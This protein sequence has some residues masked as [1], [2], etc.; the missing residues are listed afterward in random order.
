LPWTLFGQGPRCTEANICAKRVVVKKATPAFVG[1][2]SKPSS[3]ILE[4]TGGWNT[5]VLIRNGMVATP[6]ALFEADILTEGEKITKI[7][8]TGI[9]NKADVTLDATDKVVVPGIIDSHTHLELGF[10]GAETK[11]SFET[12]TRAAAFGGVTTLINYAI[13]GPGEGCLSRIDKDLESARRQAWIDF[14]IHGVITEPVPDPIEELTKYVTAGV[15]S[16][17]LF[18]TYRGAG[19]MSDDAVLHRVFTLLSQVNGL[20]GVHAENDAIV[21]RLTQEFVRLGKTGAESYPLSRPDYSEEEA[22]SRAAFFAMLC[23]SP[24]Y[25]AHLS[26]R[27]ALSVVQ[28]RRVM[29]RRLFVETCPHYLVLTDE[30][31]SGSDGI[32]YMM[33]PPL[34]DG[35]DRMALWKGLLRGDIDFISSD[36]VAF[37]RSQKDPGKGDFSKARHGIAGIELLPAL[38]YSEGVVRRDM[39]PQRFVRLTSYNPAQV[40][41]LYPRKGNIAVGADADLVVIDPRKEMTVHASELHMNVDYSVYEGMRLQGVPT[42]TI[43]RGEVVVRDGEP[44]G[45][46]GHGR[47]QERKLTPG[48]T[49]DDL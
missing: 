41:G 17:K 27:R 16:F 25:I 34:R 36:H 21:E 12:G 24:L 9:S 18:T 43:S 42:A 23:G 37:D 46:P 6:T 29:Q 28:E 4:G 49:I 40:F 14:G 20:P 13:P 39:T 11:D 8:K 3:A 7:A 15:P 19:L 38:I 31:Y 35:S 10:A 5:S 1:K 47:F 32:Q 48:M 26:T 30:K 33:S 45:T 22:V 44:W 2:S